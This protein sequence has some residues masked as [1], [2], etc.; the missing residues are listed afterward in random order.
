MGLRDKWR[1][2]K[3]KYRAIPALQKMVLGLLLQILG[4][5]LFVLAEDVAG[6]IVS[7]LR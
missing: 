4:L 2:W 1:N 7:V 5:G 6:R 3:E